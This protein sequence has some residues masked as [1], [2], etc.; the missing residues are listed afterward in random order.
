MKKSWLTLVVSCLLWAGSAVAQ[1]NINTASPEQLD[2]LKG[3]GPVR[4]GAIVDYRRKNGP[5]RSVDD[6]QKVP[7]IGPAIVHD[8]RG[9]VTVGAV[10]KALAAS[11]PASPS[12]RRSETPRPLVVEAVKPPAPARPAM[13]GKPANDAKP[14]PATASKPVSPAVPGPLAKPPMEPVAPPPAPTRPAAPARP[15]GL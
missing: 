6:L 13:P 4:A 8:L 7:G 10:G 9:E 1:V 3:I 12:S 11:A 14:L 2:S 5:F 15:A